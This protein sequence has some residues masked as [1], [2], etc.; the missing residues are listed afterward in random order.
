MSTTNVQETHHVFWGIVPYLG[1]SANLI[2]K[3][4]LGF[5]SYSYTDMY[6]VELEKM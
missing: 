5:I 2:A 6:Q 4:E 1:T 3:T